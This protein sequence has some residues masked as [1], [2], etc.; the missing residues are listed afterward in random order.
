M[1]PFAWMLAACCVAMPS[2]ALA[3]TEVWTIEPSHTFPS[4]DTS[5]LGIS[6]WRGKFNKTSGKI[7]VD[8]VTKTGHLKIEIDT[9]SVD[10]GLPILN[11]ILQGPDFLQADKYPVATYVG[12]TMVFRGDRLVAVKGEF[13]LRGITIPLTLKVLSSKCMTD[14]MLKLPHCGADAQAEFDRSKFGMT[15][16][17]VASD[18]YVR[19][20]IQVEALKGDG[21]P[22]FSKMHLPGVGGPPGG[23]PPGG[24]PGAPSGPPPGAG[25]PPPGAP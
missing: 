11:K 15:R 9:Q 21:L 3:A 12:D 20:Q 18:P 14:P 7:W 25:G 24:L 4:F 10:V 8:P 16:D 23:P 1:K 13:T 22:D 2:Y 6:F 17:L 5:H 19:L